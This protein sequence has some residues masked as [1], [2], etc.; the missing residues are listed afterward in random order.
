MAPELPFLG[1]EDGEAEP[2]PATRE[3]AI[4]P[5]NQAESDSSGRNFQPTSSSLP[6]RLPN[7]EYDPPVIYAIGYPASLPKTEAEK[8]R[9]EKLYE[10]L[11]NA[12]Q[13]IFPTA[14]DEEKT[15]GPPHRDPTGL[16]DD[17]HHLP[18]RKIGLTKT[19]WELW[20]EK[21]SPTGT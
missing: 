18:L 12:P 7:D 13:G 11:R 15:E 1:A 3:G 4:V 20:V 2:T 6:H 21:G 10:E 5:P 17:Y 16:V 9:L 14:E 19:G 8:E